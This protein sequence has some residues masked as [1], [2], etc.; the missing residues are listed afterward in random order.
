MRS[1]ISRGN[2]RKVITL[3]LLVIFEKVFEYGL[4][5]EKRFLHFKPLLVGIR[6]VA[7]SYE[8]SG[9]YSDHVVSVIVREFLCELM[10]VRVTCRYVHVCELRDH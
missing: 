2:E 3:L 8:S 9:E 5:L 6:R 4:E 10:K 1:R 7:E